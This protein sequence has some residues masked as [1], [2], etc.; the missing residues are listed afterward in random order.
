[1]ATYKRLARATLSEQLATQI[2]HMISE[3]T[4]KPGEKLPSEPELCQAFSVGRSTLREAL[5]SLSFLGTVETRHGEGTYVRQ[6]PSIVLARILG[7]GLLSVENLADLVETRIA[8]ET[9]LVRL[10]ALRATNDDLEHL[11]RLVQEMHESVQSDAK[12]FLELDLDFH[13]SIAASSKNQVL[14][15]LLQTIRGLLQ[16]L[17]EKS[18][19]L[20]GARELACEQHGKILDALQDRNPRQARSAMRRH[21]TVF[22]RRYRMLL[23]ASKSAPTVQEHLLGRNS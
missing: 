23:K 9:E 20:A 18:Q 1:M 13:L 11:G 4:W 21:L 8:L 2:G 16:E 19:E 5:K 14:A 6:S 10:C 15:S 7:H 17:I 3:G 12:R 22:Q